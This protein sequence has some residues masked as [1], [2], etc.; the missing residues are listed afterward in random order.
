MKPIQQAVCLLAALL[1]GCASYDGRGL[2]PGQSTAAQ[3][4]ALMGRPADKL[5]NAQGETV[6]FFTRAPMG[7]DT[8]AAR[9]RPDGTL[10]AVEQR[11]TSENFDKVTT[12][13][14]QK[15]EVLELLGPPWKVSRTRDAN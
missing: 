6:L 3:V 2:V 12:G 1:A 8:Y 9:L 7:R 14:M 4:E 5:V 11:L 10:I 13:K 15:R